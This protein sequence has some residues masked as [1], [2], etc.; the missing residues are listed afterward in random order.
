MYNDWPKAIALRPS[1]TR[2]A[3][4]AAHT[5]PNARR[6]TAA[7]CR[8]TG[9]GSATIPGQLRLLLVSNESQ[10]ERVFTEAARSIGAELTAIATLEQAARSIRDERFETIFADSSLARFS[11]QGFASLVRRSRLNSQTPIVVLSVARPGT[12]TGDALSPGL[13]MMGKPSKASDL[14]P[15]LKDMKSKLMTDRRKNRRLA[16]R[17]SVNCV[18]GPRHLKATS[19][20]LSSTGILLEMGWVPQCGDELELHFELA[21]HEPI[22]HG[23][24]RVVRLADPNRAGLAFLNLGGKEHGHLSRF[25]EAHLPAL[26]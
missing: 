5:M 12:I 20:N 19:A 9:R 7:Q 6:E 13:I 22:F 16:F 21:P 15:Y 11:R 10:S 8:L 4:S 17:I 24:A 25:L 3:E 1:S 18:Q 2:C 14:S 23:L 26:L